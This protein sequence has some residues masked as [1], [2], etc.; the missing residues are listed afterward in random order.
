MYILIFFLKQLSRASV[1]SKNLI[2]SRCTVGLWIFECW[3]HNRRCIWLPVFIRPLKSPLLLITVNIW[4]NNVSYTNLYIRISFG[5][6]S[7]VYILA[8]VIKTDAQFRWA[9]LWG[10]CQNTEKKPHSFLRTSLQL[11]TSNFININYNFIFL[12]R[13]VHSSTQI[14]HAQNK[15]VKAHAPQR[16]RCVFLKPDNLIL[17]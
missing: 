7:A 3:I 11:F 6:F 17:T 15:N 8:R 14:A 10:C 13:R 12:A 1:G 16:S 4:I 5:S 9:R 2:I